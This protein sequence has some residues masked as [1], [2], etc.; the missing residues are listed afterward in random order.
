MMQIKRILNWI[1]AV[2]LTI[3]AAI[4]QRF[5]GPTHPQTIPA[6][7]KVMQGATLSLLNF[8]KKYQ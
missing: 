7:G 6:T 8:F 2:V 4:Y 1:F 5:T 3:S